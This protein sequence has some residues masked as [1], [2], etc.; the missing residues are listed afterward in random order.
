MPRKAFDSGPEAL[1][2]SMPAAGPEARWWA[3]MRRW[4]WWIGVSRSGKLTKED[5]AMKKRYE[6][7][8]DEALKEMEGNKDGR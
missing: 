6:A 5:K 3:L 2:A 8:C 4:A 1:M 7:A